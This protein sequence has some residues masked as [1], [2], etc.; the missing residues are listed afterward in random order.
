MKRTK[1]PA[2]T[3]TTTATKKQNNKKK[4]RKPKKK[5]NNDHH[6]HMMYGF[7]LPA[8][9]SVTATVKR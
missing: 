7:S 3:D 5:E 8:V 6:I 1:M 2:T 9:K 4:L